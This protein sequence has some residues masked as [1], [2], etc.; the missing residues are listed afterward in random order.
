MAHWGWKSTGIEAD[1]LYFF[2]LPGW[3][4]LGPTGAGGGGRGSG[5]LV[6]Q[7]P[8]LSSLLH[9]PQ[10][11]WGRCT[12]DFLSGS[13]GVCGLWVTACLPPLFSSLFASCIS[14]TG[15]GFIQ[16]KGLPCAVGRRGSYLALRGPW[17]VGDW[18]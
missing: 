2:I 14:P 4:S 18:Q 15:W 6:G 8:L 1:H 17:P 12:D 7:L 11:M 3:G 9:G 16:T 13:L 10:W 5:R